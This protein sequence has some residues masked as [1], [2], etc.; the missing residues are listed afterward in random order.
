MEQHGFREHR[1]SKKHLQTEALIPGIQF[2]Q[3][4]RYYCAEIWTGK[5]R[6]RCGQGILTA[7]QL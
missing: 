2:G 5:I 7:I 3:A 4:S 6:D 1:D